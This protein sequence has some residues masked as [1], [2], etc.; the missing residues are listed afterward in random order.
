MKN[1]L[2]LAIFIFIPSQT[3]ANKPLT[4]E[5]MIEKCSGF[6]GVAKSAVS[7][8]QKGIPAPHMYK[9]LVNQDK[10]I[11]TMLKFSLDE[12]YKTPLAKSEVEKEAIILEFT[13]KIFSDCM[14][15]FTEESEK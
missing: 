3:F 2:F 15:Y 8:R 4:T 6:A 7:A 12:A 11:Q 10:D 14:S 1:F 9:A 13:N 5:E